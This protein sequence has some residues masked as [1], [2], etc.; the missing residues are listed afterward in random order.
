MRCLIMKLDHTHLDHV[1]L[2]DAVLL[3]THW[4]GDTILL[5]QHGCACVWVC[6]GV[7]VFK[8]E[9]APLSQLH[10][11]SSMFKQGVWESLLFTPGGERER[12]KR[13]RVLVR[14]STRNVDF[15]FYGFTMFVS[16]INPHTHSQPHPVSIHSPTTDLLQ[17]NPLTSQYP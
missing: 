8:W 3:H 11:P 9:D 1:E 6:V 15:G 13:S 4:H 17:G 14:K 10:Y 16:R 12:E 7:K 5:D 2:S